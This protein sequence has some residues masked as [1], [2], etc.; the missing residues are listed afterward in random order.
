[1]AE[2]QA[3]TQSLPTIAPIDDSLLKAGDEALESIKAMIPPEVKVSASP[4]TYGQE[5]STPTLPSAKQRPEVQ[6]MR[7]FNDSVQERNYAHSQNTWASVSNA[8]SQVTNRKEADKLAALQAA[9][10]TVAKAQTQIT[11]AQMVLQNS[12]KGPDGKPDPANQDVIN[13]TAVLEKN[14]KVMDGLLTDSKMGTQ[15]QK[16]FGLAADPEKSG[17]KTVKAVQSAVK[18][19]QQ[20]HQAGLTPDTAQE[21]AVQDKAT[22]ADKPAQDAAKVAET[23][24]QVAS[25]NPSAT[26]YADKLMSKTPDAISV[27]PVYAQQMKDKDARD[28]QVTQYVLPRLV[29]YQQGVLEKEIQA[30]TDRAKAVY[31]GTIKFMDDA[32]K[33]VNDVKVAN[34]HANAEIQKTVMTQASEM[35]RLE[36]R[37]AVTNGILDMPDIKLPADAIKQVKDQ[38]MQIANAAIANAIKAQVDTNNQMALNY[39]PGTT[40]PINLD[41]DKSLKLQLELQTKSVAFMQQKAQETREKYYG[42][43]ADNNTSHDAKPVSGTS[44]PSPKP[45]DSSSINLRKDEIDTIN[46]LTDK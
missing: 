36:L 40:E 38:T 9:T 16:A 22:G 20:S 34:I 27:N 46:T 31:T 23:Q 2:A 3:Q 33:L 43:G 39:Q 25:Q 41:L 11:N 44:S 29:T 26:P 42:A 1:M 5:T 13:A 6:M 8:V 14:K 19:V 4:Y 37:L 45:K 7:P 28:K 24:K 32:K 30:S 15:L 17:D 10:T 18:Q 35:K 21:K 12:P